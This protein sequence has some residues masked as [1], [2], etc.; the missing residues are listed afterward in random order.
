MRMNDS[1][2]SLQLRC[3]NPR[4][5]GRVGAGNPQRASE[6]SLWAKEPFLSREAD[7]HSLI[8][9]LIV[10]WFLLFWGIKFICKAIFRLYKLLHLSLP[11]LRDVFSYFFAWQI[12]F[13]LWG[14]VWV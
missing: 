7:F 9:D 12:F 14:R 6:C 4:E 2:R 5:T 10:V 1:R 8:T 11:W 13:L 3:R